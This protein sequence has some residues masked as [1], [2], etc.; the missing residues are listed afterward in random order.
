[1]AKCVCVCVCVCVCGERRMPKPANWRKNWLE[2][3][4]AHMHTHTIDYSNKMTRPAANFFIQTLWLFVVH[5]PVCECAND[6]YFIVL[7]NRGEKMKTHLF[8]GY[9]GSTHTHTVLFLRERRSAL[10]V[11]DLEA[12]VPKKKEKNC[13]LTAKQKHHLS[14]SLLLRT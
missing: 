10:I 7:H 9:T 5:R 4:V 8:D 1:M 3:K 6:I 14:L 2:R 12:V 11:A 13:R